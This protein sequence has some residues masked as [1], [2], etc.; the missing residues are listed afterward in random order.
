M[1]TNIQ[2]VSLRC[3]KCLQPLTGEPH[4]LFW[5]CPECGSGF[6][7]VRHQELVTIPLYFARKKGATNAEFLPFW[8]FDAT[9]QLGKREAKGGFFSSPK[10]LIHRFEQQQALRFYIPAFQKDLDAKEPLGLLL[11]HEQP[12]LDFLHVQKTLPIV[13]LSQE[14]ARKIADYLLITSEIE[15]KDTLRTLQYQLTLQN[16]MLI[17]ISL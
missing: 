9:L 3:T 8:A 12:E 4:S 16:P 13:D 11:T 2:L 14:D 1:S 10:G 17:A 5:F 6:E 15:Q 7:I